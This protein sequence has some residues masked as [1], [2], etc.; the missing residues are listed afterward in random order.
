VCHLIGDFQQ[1]EAER[2]AAR[3]LAGRFVGISSEEY[4]SSGGKSGVANTADRPNISSSYREEKTSAQWTGQTAVFE[5]PKYA[6]PNL[7]TPPPK[8]F[9]PPAV[10]SKP[11]KPAAKPLTSIFEIPT[12]TA[13]VSVPQEVSLF[14][15]VQPAPPVQ[16]QISTSLFTVPTKSQVSIF[17]LPTAQQKQE[18]AKPISKAEPK[19]AGIFT[20]E[21]GSPKLAKATLLGSEPTSPPVKAAEVS[22]ALDGLFAAVPSA[23]PTPAPSVSL[24]KSGSASPPTGVRHNMAV[25]SGSSLTQL[26]SFP[27]APETQAEP[28][29]TVSLENLLVEL[30]NLKVEGSKPKQ[31]STHLQGFGVSI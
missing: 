23:F 1:L 6:E 2:E 11:A 17:T 27:L 24:Q 14:D 3:K 8:P 22:S 28:K 20:M 25:Y 18:P 10:E 4:V 26:Q 9:L 21:S 15:S 5:P 12:K 13:P 29:K 7:F 30:D 19:S 16:P 31:E